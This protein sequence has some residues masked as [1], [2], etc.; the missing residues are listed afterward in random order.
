MCGRV[1]IAAAQGGGKL[2]VQFVG[3]G[4][5]VRGQDGLLLHFVLRQQ[6]LYEIAQP[7]A[8]AV[9]GKLVG[10][11]N[12]VQAPG[13]VDGLAL[14]RLDGRHRIGRFAHG[15]QQGLVVVGD[16]QVALGPAPVQ[17]CVQRAAMEDGQ[18]NGR[19]HAI[20]LAAALQ[21]AVQP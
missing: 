2:C 11:G 15:R 4:T 10:R 16:G 9:D 20:S 7:R 21:Q 12:G 17:L 19:P 14:Q 5:Q 13:L 3:A 6:Y 18:R 8:I 1:G